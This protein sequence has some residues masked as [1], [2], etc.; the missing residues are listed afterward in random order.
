MKSIIHNKLVRDK[1]PELIEASGKEC[2]VVVLQEDEF[3]EM[4]DAKLDEEL[5][6]YH[7][8]QNIEELA[9]LVEVIYA[10]VRARGYSI[11]DLEDCRVK[12]AAKC[13]SFAKKICLKEVRE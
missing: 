13:G 6:E 2:D 9:D 4:V 7:K 1:I 11:E 3:L 12:K 5:S 10:A 8:D